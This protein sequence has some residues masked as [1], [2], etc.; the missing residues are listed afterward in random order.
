MRMSV[1][2]SAFKCILLSKFLWSPG[3]GRAHPC[4][5]G[6]YRRTLGLCLQRAFELDASNDLRGHSA[7]YH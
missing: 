2:H 6:A 5:E 3:D 4:R 1:V 7:I